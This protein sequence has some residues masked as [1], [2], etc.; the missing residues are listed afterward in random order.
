MKHELRRGDVIEPTVEWLN[1]SII[2]I[3][4]L[5]Q[6]DQTDLKEE[7]LARMS[8]GKTAIEFEIRSNQK[9]GLQT[10][11]TDDNREIDIEYRQIKMVA[12]DHQYRSYLFEIYVTNTEQKIKKSEKDAFVPSINDPNLKVTRSSQNKGWSID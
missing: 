5:T 3:T 8:D 11:V 4:H 1:N 9:A 10:E 2:S 12:N 6:G 7:L